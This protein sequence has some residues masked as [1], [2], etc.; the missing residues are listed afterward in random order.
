MRPTRIA[1]LLVHV[2]R[3]QLQAHLHVGNLTTFSACKL[4]G[5]TSVYAC[6]PLARYVLAEIVAASL[7]SFMTVLADLVKAATPTHMRPTCISISRVC[8]ASR[9][10]H[11]FAFELLELSLELQDML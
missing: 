5:H 2:A 9:M 8:Y 4:G 3:K 6:V 1:H 11:L 7:D 10:T